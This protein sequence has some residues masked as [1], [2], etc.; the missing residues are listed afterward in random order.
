MTAGRAPK[1]LDGG[2]MSVDVVAVI[3][4]KPGSEDA[5]RAAMQRLVAPTRAESGNIAYDLSESDVA[6]GTFIT[7]E[8]WQSPADL[9]LH[10]QSAHVQS[11]LA[12]VGDLL[13][14]PP[15][16]HPLTALDVQ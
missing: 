15:A 16:I 3:A 13:A 11:A 6:P 2:K 8:R 5:V 1:H 10:L 14:A 12:D 9:D 7:A 4:A